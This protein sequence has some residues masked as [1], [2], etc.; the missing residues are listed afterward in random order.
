MSRKP[1][2]AA[3]RH[4]AGITVVATLGALRFVAAMYVGPCVVPIA[5]ADV[6]GAGSQ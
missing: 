4:G 6:P 5:A 3:V 1:V 2:G